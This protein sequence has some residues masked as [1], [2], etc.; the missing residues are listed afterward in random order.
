MSLFDNFLTISVK[1]AEAG[2]AITESAANAAQT[3]VERV[4][5]VNRDSSV[6]AP[7]DGPRDLDHAVSELANRTARIVHF[8]PSDPAAIPGAVDDWMRAAKFSFRFVDWKDPRTLGLALAARFSL[9]TLG[10]QVGLRGLASLEAIGAPRYLE[11]L[12]YSVQIFSEFPVYVGLEYGEVIEREKKWLASHPEDAVTRTELG[13]AL[14]KVGR[15]AE[16][17]VEL[18]RAA[19]ENPAVRSVAMHEAGLAYYNSGDFAQAIQAGCAALEAN[20]DNEPARHSGLAGVGTAR[21]LSRPCP[22]EIPTWAPG[23][24]AK[25][26]VEYEEISARCGIDKTSGGRGIAV[27]DYNNDGHL[28]VVMAAPMPASPLSQ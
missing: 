2:L 26:S 6:L 20:P 3:A 16:A 11:F 24:W 17:A 9:A 1:L 22:R 18:E 23:R 12:K 15:F 21:R 4:V 10:A 25:A 5:G 27:F 14:V 13:R 28:D 7:L 19:A 8:T